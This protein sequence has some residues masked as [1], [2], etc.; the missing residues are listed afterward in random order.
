M[1]KERRFDGISLARK[2]YQ[3]IR[4][5]SFFNS[6]RGYVIVIIVSMAKFMRILIYISNGY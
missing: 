4:L 3:E 5:P 2:Y 6:P 1:V